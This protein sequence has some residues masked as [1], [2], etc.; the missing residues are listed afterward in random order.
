L[1]AFG[2]AAGRRAH[3]ISIFPLLTEMPIE[4]L[5]LVRG[6]FALRAERYNDIRDGHAHS[7][8]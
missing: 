5:H 6:Q 4:A 8:P 3:P 1:D 7:N 2:V